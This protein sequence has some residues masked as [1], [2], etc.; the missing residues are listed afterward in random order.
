MQIRNRKEIQGT[1]RRRKKYDAHQVTSMNNPF[2]SEINERPKV[3]KLRLSCDDIDV[4]LVWT[5]K[6]CRGQERREC[7]FES[8][9]STMIPSW[10]PSDIWCLSG[11]MLQAWLMNSFWEVIS[12]YDMHSTMPQGTLFWSWICYLSITNPP[13][14]SLR[15]LLAW[16]GQ[17]EE[18][19]REEW[20]VWDGR[21]WFTVGATRSNFEAIL[22]WSIY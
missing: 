18:L 3:N 19:Y 5:G 7:V 21:D 22:P 15:E 8:I 12:Y 13:R 10:P 6:H 17:G 4:K 11:A 2:S 1:K 9:T 20:G 14:I 16:G